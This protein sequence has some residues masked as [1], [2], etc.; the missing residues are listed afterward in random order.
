M[1][2]SGEWRRGKCVICD[3][4]FFNKTAV[5]FVYQHVDEDFDEKSIYFSKSLAC[6]LHFSLF[7]VDLN[8]APKKRK[9]NMDEISDECEKKVKTQE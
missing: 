1:L 8:R 6:L 9:L 7:G 4:G 2:L 3:R 5:M